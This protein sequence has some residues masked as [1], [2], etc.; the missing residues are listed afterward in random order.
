MT[1]NLKRDLEHL[2]RLAF[3]RAEKGHQLVREFCSL[4]KRVQKHPDYP[5]L[6][7]FYPWLLVPLTLWAVD[8][9]GFG[10]HLL[11]LIKTGLR[12]DAKTKLLLAQTLALVVIKF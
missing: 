7:N 3:R 4:S 8:L 12:F 11:K 2:S 9:D 5:L 10:R 6:E 1:A